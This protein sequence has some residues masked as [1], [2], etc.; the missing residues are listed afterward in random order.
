MNA[1]DW[2]NATNG[3][4]AAIVLL[5]DKLAN[6][7]VCVAMTHLTMGANRAAKRLAE[8]DSLLKVIGRVLKCRAARD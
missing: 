8:M 7:S 2:M 6:R 5:K 4:V 3:F 1:V